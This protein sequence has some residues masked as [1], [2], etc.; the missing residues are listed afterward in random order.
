MHRDERR[1]MERCD[2]SECFGG[3]G[4]CHM[5]RDV[6]CLCDHHHLLCASF[7]IKE[8][9]DKQVRHLQAAPRLPAF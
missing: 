2:S 8:R 1:E 9:A 4:C 6:S 3:R 7:V 5:P